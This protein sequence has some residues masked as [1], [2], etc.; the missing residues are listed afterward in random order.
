MR[1]I[2]ISSYRFE[3]ISRTDIAPPLGVLALAAVLRQRCG[4]TP[5]LLDLNLI[6]HAPGQDPHDAYIEA[7][8]EKCADAD[9]NTL[10]GFSCLTTT[11]FPFMR[12]AAA[13]VKSFN[14]ESLTCIG[15]VHATLFIEDIM[16]NC[17]EL[18]FIV[19]G[20]GEEQIVTLAKYL[21]NRDFELL[22]NQQAIGWRS[23]DGSIII[24][25]RISYIQNLDTLPMPAWD[26]VAFKMYYRDH[27]N[28][29]NPKGHDIKISIPL[30][31]TRS[32]PYDCNFCS[33]HSIMGRGFRKRSPHN[34]VDEIEYHVNEF[35][36]NYFGFSDDNLTLHKNH[37]MEICNEIQRRK[38]DIQFESFNGYNLASLDEEII[39]ALVKSGCVYVILPI[40]HGNDYIRNRIIGK[41]LPREKIFD[42]MSHY[43]KHNIL[44]RG[45]FIM[46]FP[47]DTEHTLSE[48]EKMINELQPDIVNVFTLIP[49][50][51]TKVFHQAFKDNLFI[52][53]VNPAHLWTGKMNLHTSG[54]EFYIKPYMMSMEQLEYW[55][56]RFN[57]ISDRLLKKVE[58]ANIGISG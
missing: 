23:Q 14:P 16:K 47:E 8:T 28:W 31:T 2:L 39:D 37:I 55:R 45:F 17:P 4:I 18:D 9:H 25:P 57:S 40:E 20:E 43:K 3:N 54:S 32:C 10:I 15:G 29:R 1:V 42:V 48:T 11:H 36:H 22:K 24:N 46:G 27:S 50:P 38:L 49:F 6:D 51:G 7:I 56:M 34:V 13:L 26:L 19:S 41:K 53:Q 21:E 52:N 33:A 12:K 5:E 30:M 58:T 35:G 44:T